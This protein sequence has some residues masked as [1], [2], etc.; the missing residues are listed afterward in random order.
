MN[1]V[2]LGQVGLPSE[3]VSIILSVDWLLDRL[4][5]FSA[6]TISNHLDHFSLFLS[7][8][9]TTLAWRMQALSLTTL[10]R[11]RIFLFSLLPGSAR[12][13]T[14]WEI[15][16]ELALST[17]SA[18][19]SFFLSTFTIYC[20][21]VSPKEAANLEGLVE[22]GRSCEVRFLPQKI[23][24][25]FAK[26]LRKA[27]LQSFHTSYHVLLAHHHY[28]RNCCGWTSWSRRGPWS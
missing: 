24:R 11:F 1:K 22:L 23:L 5:T 19:S 21:F 27:S 4:P 15:P 13:S 8:E 17:T 9:S 2:Y 6:S 3:A 18:R 25:N 26:P 28:R 12:Q 7:F 14:F 20:P 16:L 10:T